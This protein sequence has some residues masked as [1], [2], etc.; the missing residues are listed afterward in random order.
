MKLSRV[1]NF[2]LEISGTLHTHTYWNQIN[3]FFSNS[4]HHH[5]T[6]QTIHS[7]K[8]DTLENINIHSRMH[9]WM[10]KPRDELFFWLFDFIWI[11]KYHRQKLQDLNL[12]K[13]NFE[14]HTI[15]T[16][17]DM[18][19]MMMR[20]LMMG[21]DGKKKKKR[22]QTP[23][24]IWQLSRMKKKLSNVWPSFDNGKILKKRKNRKENIN[25]K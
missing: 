4:N 17:F 19:T 21:I 5:Q 11:D 16:Q 23:V 9:V 8:F 10:A 25:I 6:P 14:I 24:A 20:L 7:I 12:A 3:F 18:M 13:K 15:Y 1:L 2:Y 22:D